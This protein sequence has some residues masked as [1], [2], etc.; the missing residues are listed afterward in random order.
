MDKMHIDDEIGASTQSIVFKTIENQLLSHSQQRDR[1]RFFCHLR[2]KRKQRR[3]RHGPIPMHH[4]HQ[5]Q[6]EQNA[7]NH[8]PYYL[9]KSKSKLITTIIGSS[10]VRN[11]SVKNIESDQ[12]EVRLRFK[13]GSDCADALAWLKTNEGQAFMFNVNQLIFII[14]TNDIHRVGADETIRRISQTI[15]S[16]RYLYPDVNMVWQLLPRGTQKT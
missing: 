16:V 1:S 3:L 2:Q 15:E 14:G 13:S 12:D 5:Q 9:L 8:H 11:I 4:H 7:F 6:Q 10:I